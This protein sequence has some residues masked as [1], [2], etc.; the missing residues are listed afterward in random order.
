MYSFSSRYPL[1]VP[2]LV[3]LL[4]LQDATP[5]LSDD[6]SHHLFGLDHLHT[7]QSAVIQQVEQQQQRRTK[8]I[9]TTLLNRYNHN[10]RILQQKSA[11]AS[12]TEEGDNEPTSFDLQGMCQ[13]IERSFNEAYNVTCTCA[14]NVIDN[15]SIACDYMKPICN[16]DNIDTSN[17][18]TTTTTTTK[19]CGIPQIAISMVKQQIFSSTTCIHNYTRNDIL[20]DDTCVFV[21][22]CAS[23]SHTNDVDA[24]TT[25]TATNRAL[26]HP[27][28]CGC[29]ASYGNEICQ[30]CH[31]CPGSGPITM[32]VDCS[33]V[34]AQAISSPTTCT[35][36]DLDLHLS[37][38]NNN[39]TT[40][41]SSS[42]SSSSTMA[43]FA[44]DFAGFCT[45]L[46]NSINNTISCDCT[47]A[48]GGSYNISCT[49]NDRVCVH[50]ELEE[51]EGE[52][53]HCGTVY[54]TV[55]VLEGAIHS[56][57]ACAAYDTE[58]FLTTTTSS[59]SSEDISGTTCTTMYLCTNDNNSS[60]EQVCHCSAT[61][62][63]QSCNSCTVIR[64]D[65]ST[66]DP[67]ILPDTTYITIDCSNVNVNAMTESPQPIYGSNSYEF[68]PFYRR[69]MKD[70]LSFDNG[71]SKTSSSRRNQ[72]SRG[73]PAFILSTTTLFMLLYYTN[74]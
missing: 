13:V 25:T 68:L 54:S 46:E 42:S 60:E 62:N 14:G 44:P 12:L 8:T 15:F 20:Q 18:T 26:F 33:N 73:I 29:T 72:L 61:Y 40:S 22:T 39:D 24:S 17:S 48:V 71:N 2:T 74:I 11:T 34:N 1:W 57:T 47:N 4:L 64:R 67:H 59:S 58:P 37:S 5:V 69:T 31:I 70:D 10:N 55:Q 35:E 38:D 30:A 7:I 50:E 36:I 3:V 51:E 23:S 66:V 56:V 6:D 45:Q 65:A 28:F 16:T 49:T 27:Q 41:T 52:D 21:D 9:T 63:D 43:G 32:S 53:I 19:T